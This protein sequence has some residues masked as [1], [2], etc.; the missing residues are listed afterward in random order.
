MP[1]NTVSVTRPHKWG[2]PFAVGKDGP[3]G[4]TPLD[5]EGAVGFFEAMLRDEEFRAAAGYPSVAEIRSE[6][7]GKNLACFCEEGAW[8]HGDVLLELANTEAQ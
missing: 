4:R 1:E 7:R 5:A 8:C 6:L 2:N 3:L